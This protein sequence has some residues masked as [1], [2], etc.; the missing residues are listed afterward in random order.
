MCLSLQGWKWHD[1][2]YWSFTVATTVGYGDILPK[3]HSLFAFAFFGVIVMMMPV[4]AL[5]QALK[6]DEEVYK[7]DRLMAKPEEI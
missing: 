1:S 6:A 5:F 2:I 3:C 7:E 4:Y